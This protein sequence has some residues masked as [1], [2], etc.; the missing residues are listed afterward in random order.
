MA[1]YTKDL[2]NTCVRQAVPLS[3]REKVTTKSGIVPLPPSDL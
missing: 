3:D 2:K 1:D